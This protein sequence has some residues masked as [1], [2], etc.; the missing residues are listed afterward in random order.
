MKTKSYS[1]SK[2]EIAEAELFGILA[3]NGSRM[4]EIE[5]KKLMHSILLSIQQDAFL[6]SQLKGMMDTAEI[7]QL[8]QYPMNL[9]PMKEMNSI[10]ALLIVQAHD[11]LKGTI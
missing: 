4:A 8:R 6:S 10:D 3:C 7:V 11:K 1:P 2:L 9:S 5:Q